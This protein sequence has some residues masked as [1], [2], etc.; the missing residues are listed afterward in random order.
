MVTK[1]NIEPMIIATWERNLQVGE[2]VLL[3]WTSSGQHYKAMAVLTK[4]NGSSVRGRL[5]EPAMGFISTEKGYT[6]EDVYS[7]GYEIVV[8]KT[9]NKKGWPVSKWSVSNGVFPVVGDIRY[10]GLKIA[11]EQRR[12]AVRKQLETT[13]EVG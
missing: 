12:E 5:T 10:L 13:K 6:L 4:V 7:E 9:S 8:P 1:E 3:R 2:A 11:T